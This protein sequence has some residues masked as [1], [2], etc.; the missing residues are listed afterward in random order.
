MVDNH[1]ID[2]DLD[3]HSVLAVTVDFSLDKTGLFDDM[4]AVDTLQRAADDWAY[5][6]A[7]MSLDE[8][9]AKRERTWIWSPHGFSGG[10]VVANQF[11]HTGFLLY[12]YGIQHDELTSGAEPSPVGGRQSSQGITL[13]L[14]RSGGIAINKRGNYNRLGWITSDQDGDWWQATNLK[15][16]PND[17]Y[18]IAR[19]G[20]GHALVFHPNHDG[21]APLKVAGQVRGTRVA[22]YYGA[23][24]TLDRFYRLAGAIDPASRRGAHGNEYYGDM[25]HGRWLVTKLDL[26]V[27]EAVGYT[28]RSTS[29]FVPLTITGDMTLNGRAKASFS[30]SLDATGGVPPY[31][32]TVERGALPNGLSLDSGTISGTPTETGTFRFTLRV[33]DYRESRLGITAAVTL[34]VSQ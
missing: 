10:R 7:D 21:F 25:P 15:D 17:L 30:G 24:P 26:L 19:N 11:R 3:R 12:A 16:V 13:P 8:T 6:F 28:L 14:R 22:E 2:Q 5:F 1:V 33:S 29:P 23:H 32:W 27:A 34:T 31:Y 4:E 18:S 20:I 9:P